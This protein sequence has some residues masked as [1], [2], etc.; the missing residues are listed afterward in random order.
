MNEQYL[1]DRSGDPDP[2]LKQLENALAPL[3]LAERRPDFAAL[4]RASFMGRLRSVLRPDFGTILAVAACVAVGFLLLTYFRPTA[5]SW[6]AQATSGEPL[7]GGKALQRGRF[8]RGLLLTT[9]KNSTAQFSSSKIGEVEVG[10]DSQIS[11]VESSSEQQL[12]SL[13]YGSIHARISA[14]PGLFVVDTPSARAIDMGCEYTLKIDRDGRGELKVSFGWVSLNGDSLQSMVPAGAMA[15]I[16]PG[17]LL[18]P[19]YFED[20]T[21]SFRQAAADFA[22]LPPDSPQRGPV[23]QTLLHEARQ[24]DAFTLL[25]LFSRAQESERLQVFDKLNQLVPAPPGITRETA[26]NWQINSMNDWWPVVQQSLGLSEIKKGKPSP[27]K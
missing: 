5:P 19:P 2:E 7:L 21:P 3:R 9:D 26:R 17:G 4:Q 24:R 10:A 11:L 12:F 27:G 23:L 16:A 6:D 1:W 22:F 20:A 13:R 25:N 18:S 15:R 8:S 14:P